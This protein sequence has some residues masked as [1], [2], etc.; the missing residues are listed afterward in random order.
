VVGPLA[1]YPE[2]HSYD[3]CGGHARSLTAPR[4][5][6]LVRHDGELVPPPG[7]GDDLT[8]L[9]E[10]VREASH[11]PPDYPPP[12]YPPPGHPPP[13][14]PA[15]GYPARGFPPGADRPANPPRPRGRPGY[16]RVVPPS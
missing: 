13:G 1:A 6:E 11:P 9:A 3:L 7:P 4:G 15:Q 14:H 8:A 12:D 10:A 5:W 16:L 2:P